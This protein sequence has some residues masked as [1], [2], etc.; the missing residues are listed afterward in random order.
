MDTLHFTPRELGSS[1]EAGISPV[2]AKQEVNPRN[3]GE[4]ELLVLR[5][6]Q[7]QAQVVGEALRRAFTKLLG[8][9]RRGRA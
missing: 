9:G 4:V 5:G 7:L 3:L 6:R 2:Y 1:G 8:F